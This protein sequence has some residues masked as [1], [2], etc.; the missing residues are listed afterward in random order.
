V[1]AHTPG[2]WRLA[3]DNERIDSRKHFIWPDAAPGERVPHSDSGFCIATVHHQARSS[4]AAIDGEDAQLEANARL[5]IAAPAM[6]DALKT[7]VTAFN[8]VAFESCAECDGG[9]GPTGKARDG[10]PCECCSEER[11]AIELAVAVIAK[12]E[13]RA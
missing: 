7:L 2:P 3:L 4:Q 6:L 10:S 5:I 9:D 13:A 12:A 11:E 8:D 1:S